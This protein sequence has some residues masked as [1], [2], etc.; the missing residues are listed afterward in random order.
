VDNRDEDCHEANDQ[1]PREGCIGGVF[2][3]QHRHMDMDVDM[4][5]RGVHCIYY[6]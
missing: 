1:H 2:G 5:A 3:E 6:V 4:Q